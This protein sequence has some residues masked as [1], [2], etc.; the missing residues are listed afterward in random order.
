MLFTVQDYLDRHENATAKQHIQERL[1]PL[2]RCQ[3]L[4]HYWLLL[5]AFSEDSDKMPVAQL[6]PHLKQLVMMRSAKASITA[7]VLKSQ[8][9]DAPPSWLLGKRI[10]TPVNDVQ[11]TWELSVG[12]LRDTAKRC[13]AERKV[14]YLASPDST[15]PLGG[16]D[17]RLMVVCRPEVSSGAASI[18]MIV[19]PA[20]RW[21]PSDAWCSYTVKLSAPPLTAFSTEAQYKLRRKAF[22]CFPNFFKVGPM[23]GGWDEA[24]W[25]AK[26]LPAS[27]TLAVK[28][29]VSKV[30]HVANTAR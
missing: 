2:I 4:S 17:F 18:D 21:I 30:G 16:L 3:H 23:A 12:D 5:A 11:L 24:K 25:A 14:H 22:S 27:G 28:L 6:R 10:I 15:P 19:A 13:A 1:G 7:A 8:L 29:T 9:A 26:G 20:D